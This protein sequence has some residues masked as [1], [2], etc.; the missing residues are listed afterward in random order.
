MTSAL[1]VLA[2][3]LGSSDAAAK[4]RPI[5]SGV[6][7]S[8]TVRPMRLLWPAL[9]A[10]YETRVGEK[11]GAYGEVVAGRYNPL[12]L[13]VLSALAA[14]GSGGEV[15]LKGT[16]FGLGGGYHYFFKDFSRG[17]YV[18]GGARF[19]RVNMSLEYDGES[20]DVT[21]NAITVAPHIGWK[22][23]GKSGFTFSTELGGGYQYA[24]GT[25]ETTIEG[26]DLN[27][28]P[29]SGFVLTGSM[30]LGWSF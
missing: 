28:T 13:R 3:T 6:D 9:D 18:G 29:E 25:G 24:T 21:A 19:D 23:V 14:G 5:N 2:M 1:L 27:A 4:D 22:V 8:V 11:G 15:D 10:R 30:N 20:A 17:W 26:G 16:T 7:H 12:G